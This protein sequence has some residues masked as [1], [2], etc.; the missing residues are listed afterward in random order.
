[1]AF[2]SAPPTSQPRLALQM[3]NQFGL[4]YCIFLF[5]KINKTKS[6]EMKE[7]DGFDWG[8]TFRNSLKF[9]STTNIFYFIFIF[10]LKTLFSKILSS[11][12]QNVGK[13]Q[14]NSISFALD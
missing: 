1:M 2:T 3:V 7:L 12:K 13:L 10:E 14:K 6:D 4:R 5:D 8:H 11:E 9:L